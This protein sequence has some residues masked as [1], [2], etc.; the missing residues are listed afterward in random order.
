MQMTGGALRRR[1]R[2][3]GR[4]GVAALIAMMSAVTAPAGWAQTRHGAHD[5][6]DAALRRVGDDSATCIFCHAPQGE[7]IESARSP[8]WQRNG[9]GEAQFSIYAVTG[10]ESAA[11]EGGASLLCLSCHDATQAPVVGGSP[12]DHPVGVPYAGVAGPASPLPS[13]QV[14]QAI[15]AGTRAHDLR[16]PTR[17][18]S[19]AVAGFRSPSRGVIDD[20]TVWWV[21]TSPNSARRSRSDL[22]LYLGAEPLAVPGAAPTIECATCH[23]PHNDNA[24]FLRISNES[25]RLCLS[26]HDV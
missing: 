19:G 22:P 13:L 16:A 11:I 21:A 1:A 12:Y 10:V 26:C 7:R 18:P 5:L 20:R 17:A 25:S 4:R 2:V 15:D 3:L 23:D 6:R 24:M 8:R 14:P 9:Q